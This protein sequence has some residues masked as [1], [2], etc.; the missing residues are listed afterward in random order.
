[1]T[2]TPITV[3][4][5]DG[6]GPEIMRAVLAILD[7]A[8][9]E[10]DIDTITI[11]QALY[12]Q[13]H[14]SGMA[15]DTWDA[16]RRTR[17]FLKAPITTPQ[18]KG[19]KSL[20]VTIRKTLSL[21]ANVRPVRS[22]EPMLASHA[23]DIDLVIVREN[24]ED[25]YGGIEHQQT[26][27]VTQ[28]LK[29]ITRPGCER[30]ARY[31]FAYAQAHGRRK[32]TCLS[33]DNIMKRTDGLFHRVFDEVAADYPDIEHEHHIIDIGTALLATAP[34]RFDVVLAPNLYGDIISDVAAQVAG[35]VGIAGSANIGEHIAMF[36]AVHGSAPDIAGMGIANPSGLLHGAIMMLCHIGQPTIAE[37]IHNA[38]LCT[39]EA[40][41][42]TGDMFSPEHS[43]EKVNTQEFRDAVMARLGD[44]PKRLQPVHY[45]ESVRIETKAPSASNPTSINKELVGVD[46]FVDW[47]GEANTRDPNTLANALQQCETQALKLQM[48]SNRGTKV[49][50]QGMP[51]TFCTDHWRCRFISETPCSAQ[52]IID[53]LSALVKQKHEVIKTENLYT[54]DGQPGFSLGQ[55]Q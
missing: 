39:L 23:K 14:S 54:F 34:Q 2:R 17:I 52:A 51:E 40:G 29:L 7:K 9:A 42:H 5:G 26:R 4:H 22:Y 27:E 12:E 18:G 24:E 25:T 53:L 33:K 21:Y 49:W 47:V 45:G 6:I 38:W 28:C 31:A 13:G 48:I 15:P 11:G 30:I 32:V 36:E 55:G 1:M 10:L 8:G 43:R 19:V 16:L 35:S 20:N 41:I 46:V 37:R 50:P 44:Q 3:A